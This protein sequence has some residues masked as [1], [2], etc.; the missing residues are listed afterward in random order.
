MWLLAPAWAGAVPWR[1]LRLALAG[2]GP[3][4]WAP[5]RAEA[6]LDTTCKWDI[7]I[8][9]LKIDMI[10][11]TELVHALLMI[12]HDIDIFYCPELL[13][14][15]CFLHHTCLTTVAGEADPSND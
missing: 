2:L 3:L 8:R 6:S 14:S 7:G 12:V 1:Q 10:G 11:D 15:Y 9:I 4:V 5:G 13:N